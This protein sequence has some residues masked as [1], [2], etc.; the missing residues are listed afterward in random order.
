M[1]R[2]V[3]GLRFKVRGFLMADPGVIGIFL[4]EQ[5]RGRKIFNNDPTN[6]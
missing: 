6:E 3:V 2:G 4:N 5:G 1:E